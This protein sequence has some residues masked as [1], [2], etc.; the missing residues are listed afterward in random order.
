[1]LEGLFVCGSFTWSLPLCFFVLKV[2][3]LIAKRAVGLKAG[4]GLYGVVPAIFSAFFGSEGTPVLEEMNQWFTTVNT[5]P[6]AVQF[7][8]TAAAAPLYLQT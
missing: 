1:M 7:K 3:S 6:W 8:D 4:C 2:V 5:K